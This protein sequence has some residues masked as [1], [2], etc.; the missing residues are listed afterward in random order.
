MGT[1]GYEMANDKFTLYM[2]TRGQ[3]SEHWAFVTPVACCS[4]ETCKG[5]R[6]IYFIFFILRTLSDDTNCRVRSLLGY[7]R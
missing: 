3:V 4:S 5:M 6:L 1:I 7:G 2:V